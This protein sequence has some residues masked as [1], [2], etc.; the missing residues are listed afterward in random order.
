MSG[1]GDFACV[2]VSQGRHSDGACHTMFCK[3]FADK[4]NHRQNFMRI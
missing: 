1:D 2:S 4:Q 3:P